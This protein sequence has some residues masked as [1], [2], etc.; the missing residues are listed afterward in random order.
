MKKLRIGV[1]GLGRIG[2][3]FHCKVL[4]K[5]ECFDLV[6]VADNVPER[7]VEATDLY[8]C[9]AFSDFDEMLAGCDL[10]VVVI[11]TP[12]HLHKKMA[13]SAFQ[14]GCH[15]F[16]E[17]PMALNVEECL[18]VVA[19]AMESQRV[20]S[21]YQPHR[22]HAYFHHIKKILESGKIGEMYHIRRGIFCYA[23]RNDWQSIVKFGGGM[24]NNY[25]A[26]YLD[27]LLQ[28][29][30]YDVD[31]VFCDMR[32]IATLGDAED[33]VKV[34]F[35]TG[36]GILAE[37]DVNQASP[38]APFEMDVWGS[39]GA[40]SL[41]GDKIIVRW[42]D[43]SDLSEK[44]LDDS[45]TSSNRAYPSDKIDFNEEVVSVDHS[46]GVDVYA[47]LYRAVTEGADPLVKPD[48]VIEVMRLIERCRRS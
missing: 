45:L 11:A 13:L 30:G 22:A 19:A 7:C 29:A 15:V 44:Q 28:L 10:D 32:N 4:A 2:W 6:A 41:K 27:Q 37:L 21:V 26:H 14:N 18:T 24:L 39:C 12:T 25:G 33:V 47:D 1:A 31:S 23:R 17:K 16:L 43:P 42:I 40:I 46:L 34:V 36:K 5:H 3:D 38:V 9:K 20:L 48:E 8:E 35:K